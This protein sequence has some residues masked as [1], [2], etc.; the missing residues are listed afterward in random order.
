MGRRIPLP[1][2][3]SPLLPQQQVSHF[4]PLCW[5]DTHKRQY[6]FFLFNKVLIRVKNFQC[7][8]AGPTGLTLMWGRM[9]WARQYCSRYFWTSWWGRKLF[10][11]G[12]KGKS[13]NIIT[14]LGRLVLLVVKTGLAAANCSLLTK[15]NPDTHT[16][17]LCTCCCGS[18]G[19]CR[20]CRLFHHNTTCRRCC[21]WAQTPPGRQRHLGG[22]GCVWL[23]R[24]QLPLHQSLPPSATSSKSWRKALLS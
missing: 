18:G 14:S 20:M 1:I 3:S 15:S 6:L 2:P 21:L 9:W 13:G 16:W 4:P 5:T 19:H 10:N 17:G 7:W 24:V 8:R 11:L 12:S 23:H 22:T